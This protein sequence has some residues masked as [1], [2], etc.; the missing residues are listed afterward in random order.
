MK[1]PE[2]LYEDDAIIVCVKPDGMPAQSDKSMAQDLVSYWK[3]YLVEKGETKEPYIAIVHRLDRPVGGVMVFAKTKEAAADLSRQVQE[4]TMVK[5][6]QAVLQGRL[7]DFEGTFDDYLIKDAKTNL[8]C[9]CDKETKGSKQAV[10]HYEVLDELETDQGIYTY[11]LIELETGRHHQIRCQ[12]AYHN[13]PIYGDNKYQAQQESGKKNHAKG[14]QVKHSATKGKGKKAAS[15][16]ALIATR[17]EFDH[18]VTKEHMVFK[19]DPWG[20]GFAILEAEEW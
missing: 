4:K 11:V 12:M 13:A 20:P 2:L 16:I 8:S 18:P 3:T 17:L 1:K 15:Q 9:V 6:Y 19:T 5:F 10:L 14:K 7:P